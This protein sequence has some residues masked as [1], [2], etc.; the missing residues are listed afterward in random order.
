MDG[1]G[2]SAFSLFWHCHFILFFEAQIS[3]RVVTLRI[4]PAEIKVI[5]YNIAGSIILT[6]HIIMNMQ[7]YGKQLCKVHRSGSY[8]PSRPG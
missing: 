2:Y 8:C 1:L 5:M 7:S 3:S 6:K 4:L